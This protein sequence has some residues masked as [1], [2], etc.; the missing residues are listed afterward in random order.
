MG[1][2]TLMPRGELVEV[3]LAGVDGEEVL[4]F[5]IFIRPHHDRDPVLFSEGGTRLGEAR[6]ERLH[7]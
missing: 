2:S 3:P 7:A 1:G 6:V 4:P 5:P